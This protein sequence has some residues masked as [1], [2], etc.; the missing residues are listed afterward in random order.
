MLIVLLVVFAIIETAFLISRIRSPSN[1]RELAEWW[2]KQSGFRRFLWVAA[3]LYGWNLAVAL[4][5][6]YVRL[7][8]TDLTCSGGRG[9]VGTALTDHSND[10]VVARAALRATNILGGAYILGYEYRTT[11]GGRFVKLN[12]RATYG[13]NGA[14]GRLNHTLTILGGLVASDFVGV[15][16]DAS[17]VTLL[18]CDANVYDPALD[19]R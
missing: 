2:S 17:N 1:R 9:E 11:S 3:G 8:Q 14:F 16:Y 5:V 12:N 13:E 4:L 10:V 15:V 6:L 18:P 19:P 7:G